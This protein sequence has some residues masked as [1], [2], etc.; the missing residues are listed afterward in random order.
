MSWWW[1]QKLLDFPDILD[2][3]QLV[4]CQTCGETSTLRWINWEAHKAEVVTAFRALP[5]TCSHWEYSHILQFAC[6]HISGQFCPALA[7]L[8][9]TRLWYC[10]SIKIFL[11]SDNNVPASRL[12]RTTPTY[13]SLF[14]NFQESGAWAWGDGSFAWVLNGCH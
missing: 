1:F 11:L 4:R 8:I 10:Y 14:H 9:L 5:F 12:F 3:G 13:C 6:T 7:T 2:L